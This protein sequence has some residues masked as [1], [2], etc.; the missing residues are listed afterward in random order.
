M[1]V[2]QVRRVKHPQ[3]LSVVF[4]QGE[5]GCKPVSRRQAIKK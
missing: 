4:G 5:T 2:L 1:V 3:E